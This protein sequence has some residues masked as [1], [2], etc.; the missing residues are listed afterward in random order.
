[1][2][3]P[4]RPTQARH[5]ANGSN[6][7]PGRGSNGGA[8]SDAEGGKAGKKAK[9]LS[10]KTLIILVAVLL[11]GGGVGYKMFGPHHTA[12]PTGGDV[13][14]LDPTTMNLL[15]GGYLKVGVSVQ[16]VKG[17]ATAT[18]FETAQAAQ[19]VLNEFSGRSVRSLTNQ[20]RKR[21]TNDLLAKMK[22]AYPGEVY[23]VF[24]TQFVTES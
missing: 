4:Q 2:S 11:I 15:N 10:K 23:Q 19:L 6:A 18:D 13:V 5:V 22:A 8:S 17:K 9:R 20:A 16:L 21:L 1:M 24:I 14:A 7:S 12:P 3:A